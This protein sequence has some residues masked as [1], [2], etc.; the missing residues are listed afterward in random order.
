MKTFVRMPVDLREFIEHN[1]EKGESWGNCLRRLLKLEN[2]PMSKIGP[3]I[4]YHLQHL[5]VG[6]HIDFE[7]GGEKTHRALSAAAK[8]QEGKTFYVRSEWRDESIVCRVTRTS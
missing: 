4:K 8:R 3:P 5:S 1:Q 7:H 2:A 6:D